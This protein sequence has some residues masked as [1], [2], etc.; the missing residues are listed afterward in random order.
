MEPRALL[1]FLISSDT[2]LTRHIGHALYFEDRILDIKF[3]FRALSVH[4]LDNETF[5]TDG[6]FLG[7]GRCSFG[8]AISGELSWNTRSSSH[9]VEI[10]PLRTVSLNVAWVYKK[11]T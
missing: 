9:L 3:G 7:L 6:I 10:D 1:L 5:R 8:A 11:I 2:K 4:S